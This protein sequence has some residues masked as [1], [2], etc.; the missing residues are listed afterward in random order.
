MRRTR[1][2]AHRT[3]RGLTGPPAP[4]PRPAQEEDLGGASMASAM[5]STL[6]KVQGAVLQHARQGASLA[7]QQYAKLMASN[8]QYVLKDKAAVDLMPK[9]YFFTKLSECVPPPALL[10]PPPRPL[11]RGEDKSAG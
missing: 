2:P 8:A 9:Q 1:P 10:L 11:G 4:V 6:T 3:G 5:A 7:E